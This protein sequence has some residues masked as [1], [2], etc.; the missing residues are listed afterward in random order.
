[1]EQNQKTAKDYPSGQEDDIIKAY[2]KREGVIIYALE[3][4]KTKKDVCEACTCPRGDTLYMKI[5]KNKQ[6]QMIQWGF[7]PHEME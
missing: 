5:D 6:N 4:K 7:Q 2:F 1:M 3:K